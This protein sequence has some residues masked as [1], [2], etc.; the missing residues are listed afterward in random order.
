MP[1]VLPMYTVLKSP[2]LTLRPVAETDA[3][4]MHRLVNTD[5]WLRF[6]GNRNIP[7]AEHALHYIEKIR[8]T[9]NFYY[10]VMENHNGQPVGIVSLLHREG[11]E[12]PDLGFALL[13]EFEKQG[14]AREGSECYLKYLFESQKCTKVLAIVKPDNPK[15]IQLVERLGFQFER[16][17]TGPDGILHVFGFPADA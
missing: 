6:I 3:E 8:A 13:P 12:F 4:F 1:K 10:N 11:Y 16:E 17:Q 5:G 2:R 7:D 14:L 9:P 15:S